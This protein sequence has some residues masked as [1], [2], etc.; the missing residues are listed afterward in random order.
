MSKVLVVDDEHGT[1]TLAAEY[2]RLE[3]HDVAARFDGETG[4]SAL[5]EGGYAV[6]VIDRRLPDL[7]GIALCARIKGD[8]RTAGVKVLLIS[9]MGAGVALGAPASPDA[10]LAKPF[11]PKDL[12]AQVRRLVE[13]SQP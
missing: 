6:A 11:R 1:N 3:G 13:T 2:L 4:W 8:A 10:F 9:A 7:D 5:L 12:S